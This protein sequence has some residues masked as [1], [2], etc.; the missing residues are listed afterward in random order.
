MKIIDETSQQPQYIRLR[1]RRCSREMNYERSIDPDVPPT[2]TLIV[3]S[4]CDQC[5]NGD[6]GTETWYDE[7]DREVLP[8]WAA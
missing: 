3:S 7:N 1:C 4:Q 5:D 6:F 2:V 8:G